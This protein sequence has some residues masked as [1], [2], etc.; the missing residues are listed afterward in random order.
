MEITF[1][2]PT[3]FKNGMV[4]GSFVNMGDN[5]VRLIARDVYLP[6]GIQTYGEKESIVVGLKEVP[7]ELTE[8][9][10]KAVKTFNTYEVKPL[11][12]NTEKYGPQ[13]RIGINH[14]TT[15]WQADPKLGAVSGKA[16]HF[17]PRC[18]VDILY[19]V[20]MVWLRGKEAGISLKLRQMKW[21]GEGDEPM[22]TEDESTC[23]L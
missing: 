1:S 4:S 14:L 16:A 13:I 17:T 12:Q 11:I 19:E 18:R 21:V 6:F 7:P 20:N 3:R 15:Y 10:E 8:V 2:P 9:Y 22:D 5:P 23:A